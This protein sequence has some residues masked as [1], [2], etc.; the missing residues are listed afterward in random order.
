MQ[1]TAPGSVHISDPATPCSWKRPHARQH[2]RS[3]A[4]N[5]SQGQSAADRILPLVGGGGGNWVLRRRV[6]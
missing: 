6:S 3:S 4:Y 5:V 1:K 2:D